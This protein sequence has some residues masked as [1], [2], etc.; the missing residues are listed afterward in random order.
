[1]PYPSQYATTS[2]EDE[3]IEVQNVSAGT[4]QA[5]NISSFPYGDEQDDDD[6][7]SD[8]VDLSE[9][10]GRDGEDLFSESEEGVE[11]TAEG[12]WDP[13]LQ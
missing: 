9:V 10:K 3:G 7:D 2:A 12:V 6:S 8:S 11:W 13:W 1:M 5:L 4:K